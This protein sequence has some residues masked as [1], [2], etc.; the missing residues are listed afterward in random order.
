MQ[1]LGIFNEESERAVLG[2]ILK[3]EK[4]LDVVKDYIIDK[5]A[6]YIEKHQTI[7]NAIIDLKSENIPI[8]MVNISSKVKGIT[9]YI[10]GLVESV[11][12]TA[13]VESY[14]KQLHSDWLRRKL[15]R[16]SQ[17][18]ANKASDDTNDISSLLVNVHDTASSL[19]NLEPGQKFDL[20]TLLSMTK[21]SLFSKRS[22]TTTGFEPIDNIISGMTK[23]EI[24]IFAG[25]PGNAKTTTVANIARNLVLAGKKV[26][27]FNREMP[28]TEMMKKF[29][30]MESE[31][32]TYHMLRHNAVTSKSEIEKSLNVIKER[33]TD[34]LFMFDNISNL[35]GTFR[36]IRRIKPDVVIDDHIGLIEYPTND[37]RDLRLKIGDTSRKYKWL[38]KSEEMSVIL[39]S[40]LNRNIE[41]RTERI[42]KLSDL[43]ESGNLEQ[44]AEIVAFTHYPWTVNFE[45]AK[46]GKFGLDIVV[47]KNRYGSTGKAT[48]GFSPDTCTLYDTIEEAEASVA[49]QMP[50]VPF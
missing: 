29:I 25:R 40:Q 8:D 14:A 46:H 32:I 38:C 10:T 43:A 11:P 20:D 24:T 28:N 16:Q 15:I 39:V 12:S 22:L 35:E 3:D 50:D 23:G 26:V 9:Y 42:P 2:S 37:M 44:D 31:G 17:E 13:N 34:K 19:L 48:V 33:Y 30:A 5:D 36:E 18:I 47:A 49:A 1:G 27:M 7:W 4:C 45:N 6:F 41:Y 21:D